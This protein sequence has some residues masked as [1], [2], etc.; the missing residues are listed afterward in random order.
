MNPGTVSTKSSEIGTRKL[1]YF[2]ITE[3][4]ILSIACRFLGKAY[5]L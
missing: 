2:L 5:F 3:E 4:G 1:S